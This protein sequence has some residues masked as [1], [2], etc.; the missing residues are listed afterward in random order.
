MDASKRQRIPLVQTSAVFAPGS[1][2]TV[3]VDALDALNAGQTMRSLARDH[4]NKMPP[5]TRELF[6]RVGSQL[7]AAALVAMKD[8]GQ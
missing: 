8:G 4:S 6:A 7:T 5:G 3:T 2:A 1:N